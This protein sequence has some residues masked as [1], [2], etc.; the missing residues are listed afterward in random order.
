MRA[1]VAAVALTFCVG[2]CVSC[3]SYVNGTA[4]TAATGAVSAVTDPQSKAEL[5][6]LVTSVVGTARDQ[7]LGPETQAKLT[8]LVQALGAQLQALVKTFGDQ[9]R[10]ELLSTR[11]AALDKTLHDQVSTLRE[12][13][14]GAETRRLLAQLLAEILADAGPLR[15]QLVGAPLRKDADALLA[16]VGPRLDAAV[17]ASLSKI[18]AAAD[19][20][21]AKY[22][23]LLAIAGV[24][25]VGVVGAAIYLVRSHRK[26][27]EALLAKQSR[28]RDAQH[29]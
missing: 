20:E 13:L 11:D 5:D 21:V 7:A 14:L 19:A 6:A 24:L 8:A 3:A 26:I 28:E 2:F 1:L 10:A 9:L 29:G 12:E 25:L 15:E 4:S 27:I 18:T 22:K 16:D 17:Q 23:L